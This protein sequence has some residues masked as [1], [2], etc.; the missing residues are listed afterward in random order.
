[1]PSLTRPTPRARNRS[2]LNTSAV[3][4]ESET[5][6][7]STVSDRPSR[8]AKDKANQR[9]VWMGAAPCG[10][11]P[12][13]TAPAVKE[14]AADV[15][16]NRKRAAST[17]QQPVHSKV[18]KTSKP[19]EVHKTITDDDEQEVQPH[20]PR[21]QRK[22]NQSVLGS[23]SDCEALPATSSTKIPKARGPSRAQ[24]PDDGFA[25]DENDGTGDDAEPEDGLDD[26][27]MEDDVDD[28]DGLDSHALEAETFR[29]DSSMD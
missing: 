1:M 28:L 26:V 24:D 19:A 4:T 17:V 16:N 15:V 7:A 21:L 10:S 6:A 3:A 8:S 12:K 13:Q 18:P 25:E 2:S 27:E 11:A 5:A 14:P 23:D 9:A 22:S 29:S 20:R